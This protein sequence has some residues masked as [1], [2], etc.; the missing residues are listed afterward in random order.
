MNPSGNSSAVHD[1][2]LAEIQKRDRIPPSMWDQLY[3]SFR[4]TEFRPVPI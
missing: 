1:F 4:A 3:S 2:A